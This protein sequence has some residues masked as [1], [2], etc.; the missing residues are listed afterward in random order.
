[1][2]TTSTKLSSLLALRTLGEQNPFALT[3]VRARALQAP[4]M[5]EMNPKQL[6]KRERRIY[7]KARE[8]ALAIGLTAIKGS[9]AVGATADL[10]DFT[11]ALF[12]RTT[13]RIEQRL[14]LAQDASDDEEF[15]AIQRIFAVES[16]KRMGA[17][18][19]AIADSTEQG[20]QTIVERELAL[21][22]DQSLLQL[23]FR[24]R[25]R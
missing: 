10:E 23:V 19:V 4:A 25:R 5:P 11:Q 20:M 2:A 15:Q 22:D 9:L 12:A 21:D 18:M 8:D 1:M 14:R 13:T 7:Q 24:G 3:T 6:A 16:S 17:A